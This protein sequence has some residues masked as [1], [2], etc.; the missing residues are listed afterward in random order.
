MI[1]HL[2][3]IGFADFEKPINSYIIS[4]TWN[5]EKKGEVPTLPSVKAFVQEQMT[6]HYS[7]GGLVKDVDKLVTWFNSLWT[8]NDKTSLKEIYSSAKTSVDSYLKSIKMIKS[9]DG[10][11]KRSAKK[12]AP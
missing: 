12:T 9:S 2:V 1:N 10:G 6:A 4:K 5:E 11:T 7:A 3:G 8:E